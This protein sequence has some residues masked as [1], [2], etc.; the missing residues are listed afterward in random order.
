MLYSVLSKSIALKINPYLFYSLISLISAN[1]D[2]AI[3]HDHLMDKLTGF[4]SPKLHLVAFDSPKE[5]T[6]MF[7]KIATTLKG[8]FHSYNTFNLKRPD[9]STSLECKVCIQVH[10]ATLVNW[11][12]HNPFSLSDFLCGG[13]RY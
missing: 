8:H 12:N 9:S 3:V 13:H 4:N 10:V 6:S 5:I 7:S 2:L 1:Q 11:S